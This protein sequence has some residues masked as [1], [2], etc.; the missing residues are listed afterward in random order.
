MLG[1]LAALLEPE[2]LAA[3]L[4]DGGNIDESCGLGEG[5]TLHYD[6]GAGEYILRVQVS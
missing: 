3:W 1:G 6:G 4:A 2:Q 5:A